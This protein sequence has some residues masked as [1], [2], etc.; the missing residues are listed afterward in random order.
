[1]LT[2]TEV[3]QLS[4]RDLVAETTST[5]DLLVRQRMGTKTRHLKD[6]HLINTLKIHLARLLTISAERKANG[7]EVKESDKS[8]TTKLTEEKK[9]LTE[10]KTKD[11]KKASKPEQ[12][13]TKDQDTEI[14][15]SN[16]KVKVKKVEKKSLLGSIL[17]K[18]DS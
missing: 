7:T 10:E 11:K 2:T 16:D 4:D 14:L 12:A 8:V 13:T 15:K 1:M 17:K 3:R 6:T 18:K 9:K 5:R